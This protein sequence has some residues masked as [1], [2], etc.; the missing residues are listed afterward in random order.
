LKKKSSKKKCRICG[1]WFNPNPR[2]RSRQ[3]VCDDE[4]C[5]RKAQKIRCQEWR[6]RNRNYFRKAINKEQ[7]V[8]KLINESLLALRRINWNI[9][10]RELGEEVGAILKDL[11][12]KQVLLS[13]EI[14]ELKKKFDFNKR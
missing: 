1:K 2:C 9:V 12:S 4:N 10:N 7:D 14:V 5:K 6:E 8:E 3:T 11:F 13:T